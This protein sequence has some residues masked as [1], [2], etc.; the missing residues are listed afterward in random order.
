MY[1]VGGFNGNFN[2]GYIVKVSYDGSIDW[3]LAGTA[4]DAHTKMYGVNCQD[5]YIYAYGDSQSTQL[6][7]G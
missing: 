5:D 4:T 6:S 7:N 2:Q 1:L 3:M